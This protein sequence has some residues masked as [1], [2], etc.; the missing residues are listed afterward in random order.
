M[1]PKN[2]SAKK[3]QHLKQLQKSG[4]QAVQ[5]DTEIKKMQA[6]ILSRSQQLEKFKR[7]A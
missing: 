3:F 4:S 5:D 6:E 7:T 2:K 1:G